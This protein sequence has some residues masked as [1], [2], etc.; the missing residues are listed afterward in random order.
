MSERSFICSCMYR[1]RLDHLMIFFYCTFSDL[2]K[3]DPTTE[4]TKL[5]A[6]MLSSERVK[7]NV[8]VFEAI[9]EKTCPPALIDTSKLLSSLPTTQVSVERLFS[10]V[11]L[12]LSDLRSRLRPDIVDSVL[13]LR[14]N[15]Q[16][17]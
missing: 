12:L 3:E 4:F 7:G 13:F 8:P 11:K 14:S 9:N 5:M 17:F 16:H 15:T 1:L 2:K 6:T 10:S